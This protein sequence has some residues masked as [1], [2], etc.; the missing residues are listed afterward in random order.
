MNFCRNAAQKL[1]CP[2]LSYAR[3]LAACRDAQ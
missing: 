2:D 3:V 1:E